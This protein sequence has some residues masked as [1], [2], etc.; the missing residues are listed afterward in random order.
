MRRMALGIAV[1][2]IVGLVVSCGDSKDK[3]SNTTQTAAAPPSVAASPL[4]SVSAIQKKLKSKGITCSGKPEK[5]PP[6]LGVQ[7]KEA[8]K[9]TVDGVGIQITVYS[10]AADRGKA[11][12]FTPAVSCAILKG[13]SSTYVSAGN[14]LIT[15]TAK[16]AVKVNQKIGAAVAAK[17]I[18]IT[19]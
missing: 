12:G 15:F 4:Q 14:W 10:S 17:P 11:Q 7:A 1:I 18:A 13:K 19:C 9:C 8:V 3:S 5:P 6:A 2:A 16:S